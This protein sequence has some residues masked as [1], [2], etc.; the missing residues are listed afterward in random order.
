MA[1]TRVCYVLARAG[2]YV[3]LLV[4]PVDNWLAFLP[5][6]FSSV[7]PS[8]ANTI[9]VKIIAGGNISCN[10]IIRICICFN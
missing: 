2:P 7:F 4:R 3:L 6:F 9:A 10:I 1:P 5:P 8:T